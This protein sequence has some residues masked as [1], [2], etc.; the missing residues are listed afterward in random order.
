M[1]KPNMKPIVGNCLPGPDTFELHMPKALVKSGIGMPQRR[2]R[3]HT[4]VDFI[5]G[6][7]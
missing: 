4:I 2:G 6:P 3:L 1:Q 5:H 7:S